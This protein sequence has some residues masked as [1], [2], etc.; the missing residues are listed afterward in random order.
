MRWTDPP[1]IGARVRCTDPEDFM[2]DVARKLRNRSGTVVSH[3]SFSN[4][5]IILFE[6][7]GRRREFRWVPPDPRHIKLDTDQQESP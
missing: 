5:P 4:A 6:A 7:V 1:P 3:Q 2:V